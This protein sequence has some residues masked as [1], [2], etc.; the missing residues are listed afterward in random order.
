MCGRRMPRDP[1]CAMMAW[2]R[3]RKTIIVDDWRGTAW[4]L[5]GRVIACPWCG[6]PL[7][8]ALARGREKKEDIHEQHEHPPASAGT[9]D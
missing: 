8:G 5:A 6:A 1:C 2:A 7:H 4:C 9:T 3:A